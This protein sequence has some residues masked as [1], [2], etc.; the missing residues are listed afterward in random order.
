MR[1]FCHFREMTV[2]FYPYSSNP[3]RL[4]RHQAVGDM[5]LTVK[6]NF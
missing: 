5:R 6:D 2:T 4:L 3:L 1:H